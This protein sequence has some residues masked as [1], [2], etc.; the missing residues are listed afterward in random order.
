MEMEESFAV[1]VSE[2]GN[3]I[4]VKGTFEDIGQGGYVY[5]AMYNPG[6]GWFSPDTYLFKSYS[7]I[8]L[9]RQPDTDSKS[10]LKTTITMPKISIVQIGGGATLKENRQ[11][12][13]EKLK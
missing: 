9:K 1:E 11:M 7:D 5:P 2:D 3:T 4:T 10:Y 6:A 12:A 8:V 13:V